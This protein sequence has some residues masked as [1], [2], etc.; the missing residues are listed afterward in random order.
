M[1][2]E[3]LK[4]VVK[5]VFGNVATEEIN[6][7][8]SMKCVLSR[9]THESGK[10]SRASAGLSIHENGVSVYSCF[11]CGNRM[12]IYG[13]LRKYAGYTGEDLDELIEELE[14]HAY[15]GPRLLP[16]WEH[17]SFADEVMTPLKASVYLDLYD[18]AAGHPYLEER[19]IT[20]ATAKL[21]Q[22][23]IDP[24]HP[25]DG[26]ERIL[27]PV[28]GPDG[29]LYGLTG[30]ATSKT[31]KLKVR[32]YFGLPKAG[33]VLGAHLVTK[34]KPR[35]LL[36]VEGLFDYANAWQQGYA[37]VAVMH[38]S[39]TDR[40]AAIVRDFG[41]PT[42]LFFDDDEAG[43]KGVRSA[44]DAL[45]NYL[46]VMQVRY[47][48]IWIRDYDSEED[49]HFVKDPG[50]LEEDEFQEMIDDAKLYIPNKPKWTG[51]KR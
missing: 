50:E 11:T 30:R 32:D 15:L 16:D 44:G 49:G 14:D 12:P 48:K 2:L 40:Q 4:Q 1:N 13:M 7:W 27:F 8:L 26:E 35:Y 24:C 18:P 17:K 46:P 45:Y 29:D 9:W 41:I 33:C 21:L 34:T 38:S 43:E 3:E 37:A 28:F 31:A 25:S 6:G 51:K 10:D 22:L 20:E 47:P 39:M 19:G 36:V 5:E 42:F 23:M